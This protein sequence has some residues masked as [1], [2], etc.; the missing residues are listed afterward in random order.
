MDLFDFM[1]LL[2]FMDDICFSVRYGWGTFLWGLATMICAVVTGL[3]FTFDLV[4]L[5][6]LAAIGTVVCLVLSCRQSSR[7]IRR[8]REEEARF[9]EKQNAK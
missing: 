7:D 6:V 3:L 8:K 1:D 4:I 9:R 2:A 5:G